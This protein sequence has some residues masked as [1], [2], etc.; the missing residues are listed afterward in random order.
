M[1]VGRLTKNGSSTPAR[2]PHCHNTSATMPMPI[3]QA[4]TDVRAAASFRR[5]TACLRNPLALD[6]FLTK[7]GPYRAIQIDESGL[8]PKIEEVARPA[9]GDGV[10]RDD[11]ARRTGRQHDHF[12]GERE[13]FFEIVR[14]EDDGLPRSLP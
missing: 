12:V 11:A 1:S 3:C 13:R 14:H 5:A 10:L 6:H 8:R 7:I 9:E 4:R 2:T